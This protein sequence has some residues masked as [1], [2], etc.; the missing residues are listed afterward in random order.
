MLNR[1]LLRKIFLT[2]LIICLFEDDCNSEIG[3]FE[4]ALAFS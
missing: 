2:F 3:G 1:L 4:A